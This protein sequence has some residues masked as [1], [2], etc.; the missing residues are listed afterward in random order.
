[1]I[2]V[3]I[4]KNNLGTIS[5]ECSGHAGYAEAGNDIICAA[6]SALMINTANSLEQL[7]EDDMTVDQA[8][9]GGW[10]KISLSETPSDRALVLMDSLALGLEWIEKAYGTTFLSVKVKKQN[11]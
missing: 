6:V 2:R 9:D 10:L 11:S 5:V 8:E 1:M 4:L 7:T 3:V